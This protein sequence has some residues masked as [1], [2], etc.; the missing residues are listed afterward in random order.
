MNKNEREAMENMVNMYV[1]MIDSGD[2]G[3]WDASE[4]EEVKACRSILLDDHIISSTTNTMLSYLIRDGVE[5]V[6]ED[7]V[8]SE[9]AYRI[10]MLQQINAL[11]AQI[12]SLML[13]YCPDE[14]TKEQFE[15][16]GKHQK[17]VDYDGT[18]IKV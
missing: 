8:L 18:D 7:T 6:H 5:A 15:N 13:E 1:N 11:Q 2:C 9:F 12:D 10:E 3:N 17:A 4:D 14:M 16:W